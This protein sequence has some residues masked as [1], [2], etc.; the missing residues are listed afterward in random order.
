MTAP[1]I[2]PV[3]TKADRRAFVVTGRIVGAVNAKLRSPFP[4]S[5]LEE[6]QPFDKLREAVRGGNV[7]DASLFK[8]NRW[9]R[10]F[11]LIGPTAARWL[12]L[13]CNLFARVLR[14]M[15]RCC[16]RQRS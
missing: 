3:L 1:T 14:T 7:G 13:Q 5:S 15:S 12:P 8:G 11:P 16:A 4:H 6:V 9:T 10:H 2:R